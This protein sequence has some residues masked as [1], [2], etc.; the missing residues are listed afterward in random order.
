MLSARSC[1]LIVILLRVA[2]DRADKF[3]HAGGDSQEESDNADP[4]SV[5]PAVEGG[6]EQP[7]HNRAGREHKRELA[8]SSDLHPWIL[9]LLGSTVFGRSGSW[10]R[11]AAS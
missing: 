9:P 10:H 7:S 5:Q 1:A 6:A 2:Q 8:I 11:T 3:D 4:R